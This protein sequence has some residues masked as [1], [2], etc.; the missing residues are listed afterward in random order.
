[1]RFLSSV[2]LTVGL[3]FSLESRCQRNPGDNN[4]WVNKEL[5]KHSN[6]LIL[7]NKG[8]QALFDIIDTYRI[9]SLIFGYYVY[10]SLFIYNADTSRK[11]EGCIGVLEERLMMCADSVLPFCQY[12]KI[13]FFKDE[14]F[15][16]R[17]PGKPSVATLIILY[18]RSFGRRHKKFIRQ[19]KEYSLKTGTP[20]TLL[21]SDYP[22]E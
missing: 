14:Y 13:Q 8:H 9:S 19:V 22:I 18:S 4:K 5:T 17:K 2:V 20:Y 10:D 11:N 12:S 15:W 21:F 7:N 1:M 16:N 3:L 6:L